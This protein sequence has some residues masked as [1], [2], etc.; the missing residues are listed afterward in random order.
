MN[1]A[2]AIEMKQATLADLIT[3][4]NV[5]ME[6]ADWL[7]TTG[8]PMWRDSELDPDHLRQDVASGLFYLARCDGEPAG[9]LKFQLTDN[10]FWPDLPGE[11]AAYV[12]RVAVKR[13]F[14][15]G[16]VSS[17]MLEW[18]LRHTAALGRTYLRLDCEAGR[19]RLRA[20]YER[21][22][23]RFHSYRHVGPYF[24]ARYEYS[25]TAFPRV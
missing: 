3:V 11:D 12:H 17:A 9:T 1:G 24:V 8:R 22:G 6:A 21:V 10:I 16:R 25:V 13:K 18:V 7:C 4:S 15:G 19:E 5:L 14:A 20:V 2:L 23:F